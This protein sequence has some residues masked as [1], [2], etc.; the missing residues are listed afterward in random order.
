MTLQEIHQSKK[1]K[2][3]SCSG[4]RKKLCVIRVIKVKETDEYP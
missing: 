4:V 3:D 2:L 1:T